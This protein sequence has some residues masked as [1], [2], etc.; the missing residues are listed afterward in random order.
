MASFDDAIMLASPSEMKKD[1]FKAFL[2]EINKE[3][4]VKEIGST[5]LKCALLT[6]GEGDVYASLHNL[7]PK[8][9]GLIRDWDIAAADIILQK[10]GGCLVTLTG[11]SPRYHFDAPKQRNGAIGYRNVVNHP[12]YLRKMQPHLPK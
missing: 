12:D 9:P 7:N 10:A 1:Y 6:L 3:Q 8:N 5:A 2:R 4:Q 11:Y